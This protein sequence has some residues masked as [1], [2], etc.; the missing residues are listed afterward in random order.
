ML[1]VRLRAFRSTGKV[2]ALLRC[3]QGLLERHGV[4]NYRIS[5]MMCR[6]TG[7]NAPAAPF[8]QRIRPTTLPSS[9]TF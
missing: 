5:P 1:V 2:C 9:M 4:V 6:V 3:D 8:V 7:Q